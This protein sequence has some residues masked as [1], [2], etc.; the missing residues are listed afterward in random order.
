[1][2][3][4]AAKLALDWPAPDLMPSLEAR[5]PVSRA[6][7]PACIGVMSMSP[8]SAQQTSSVPPEKDRKKALLHSGFCLD[9]VT[10][11]PKHSHQRA[12]RTYPPS[13]FTAA[14]LRQD[15]CGL[16]LNTAFATQ[17]PPPASVLSSATDA[18]STQILLAPGF[19]H[20]QRALILS[21]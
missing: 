2:G 9:S 13:C 10:D 18:A 19:P 4:L 5:Q 6:G 16:P 15:A 14:R 12:K 21:P 11:T 1:M 3:L 8:F 17:P 20:Y 7:P